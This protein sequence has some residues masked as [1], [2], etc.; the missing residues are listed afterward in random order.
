[1]CKVQAYGTLLVLTLHFGLIVNRI[2]IQVTTVE[3]LN[4][5]TVAL[6]SQELCA[7]VGNVAC[8]D[9]LDLSNIDLISL[10][11]LGEVD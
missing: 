4:H 7:S 3:F 8:E 9:S 6:E 1:M 10:K 5:C 2:L 11:I